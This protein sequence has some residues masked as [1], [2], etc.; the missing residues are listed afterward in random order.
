MKL[1]KTYPLVEVIDAVTKASD[2]HFKVADQMRADKKYS[3]PITQF[4]MK[5]M[6]T[7]SA[8]ARVTF[9]HKV[10]ANEFAGYMETS[11]G[12]DGPRTPVSVIKHDRM[13]AANDDWTEF[14][15]LNSNNKVEFTLKVR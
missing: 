11:F 7:Q 4:E 3:C 15:V 13:M 6:L 8:F 12:S 14:R 10:G 1:N 5:G 9:T 2:N